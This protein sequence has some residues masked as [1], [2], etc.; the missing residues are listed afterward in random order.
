MELSNLSLFALAALIMV[1]TP[2]PNMVYLISRSLCQGPKAGLVSLVGVV[3]GFVL[4]MLMAAFGISAFF[5]AVP[6]AYDALRFAGAGYLLWLAWQAIRPGSKGAF[7]VKDLKADSSFR[8]VWMGFL[9]NALNPKIAIFYISIFTQFLDPEN[10]SV[11]AQS[12]TLGIVQ[13]SIS[14]AVNATIV[15]SAAL[16]YS[17]FNRKPTWTKIQKW[18]MASSLSGLALKLA[19][20]ERK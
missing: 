18:V 4:H 20:E 10:A 12:I 5:L 11:F 17:F 6:I 9:T 1:L 19:V 15:F 14:A 13:I 2:G 8:L 3:M 7:E 16:V